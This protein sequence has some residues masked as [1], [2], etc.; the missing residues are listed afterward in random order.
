MYTKKSR[1]RQEI[2]FNQV[3][4]FDEIDRLLDP[5][6]LSNFSRYNQNGKQ[7]VGTLKRHSDGTLAENLIIK[8]N[9]LVALH[10][11]LATKFKERVKLIYIDPPYN[12]GNDSFKYNDKFNHSTWLTFMKNRLEIARELLAD[13]GVIFVQCD[14]NEQAY[15]K[16]LMDEVFRREN[17]INIVTVKTKIGGVSGSSEGKSLRDATEFLLLSSKDKFKLQ[18]NPVFQKTEISE[19][20]EDY[21]STGK[22]WKYTQVLV[23]LGEKFLLEEQDDFK[24]YHYPNS[25]SVSIA[26]YCAENNLSEND[27]YNSI[28]NKVYRTTNAQSSI[29]TKIIEDLKDIKDGIVSIEYTPKKGKN[30]GQV[31]EVFYN[32]FNKDMFMFLSDMLFFENKKFFYLQKINTLWEDIQY[33]NLNKEGDYIDFTNGKKPEQLI[34]RIIELATNENDIILDFHLGSGT[35]AAVAHKMNRQYIGIEQM[36]YIE[37]LAVER[38]KKVIDGEQSGISKA[39][40]W[41]GGGE[42]VYF[43]LAAF[44]EKA[45][46]LILACEDFDSLKTLFNELCSRYFLKYTLSIKEFADIMQEAEFQALSLDEQKQ[47]MLEMLDLNQLY[48]NVS[49]MED[50]QFDD[51]LSDED[52]N[53]TLQFYGEQ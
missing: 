16:V 51:V 22:S 9:N 48:V 26:K 4:A 29:R 46:D 35:T 49:D 21:K 34:K 28:S 52:K 33:N 3:L 44:N 37:T 8:G 43:E 47:M 1:K 11:L 45:K 15:L 39:A 19:Y 36:D 42:F 32:G 10:T 24:Y 25:K 2:F 27:V 14:D 23:E 38:L 13:D 17:F 6:A 50:S 31:T 7:P 18:L 40:N 30:K 53:L 12:T 5:K 20:V 41:Q